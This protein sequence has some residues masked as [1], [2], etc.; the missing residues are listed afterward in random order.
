MKNTKFAIIF[1]LVILLNISC[2]K[3]P[4]D[5]R[6]KYLGNWEFN[7][8]DRHEVYNGTQGFHDTTTLRTYHGEF[9]YGSKHSAILFQ[10]SGY[11]KEFSIKKDGEIFPEND[12]G[13]NYS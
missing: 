4:F 6:N 1:I 9:K 5:F 3:L 11:S 2:E 8:S 10:A 12:Y 13:P 7:L